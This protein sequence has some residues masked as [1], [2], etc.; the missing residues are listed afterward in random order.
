MP[1]REPSHPL[2][3]SQGIQGCSMR[4]QASLGHGKSVRGPGES[5]EGNPNPK[6]KGTHSPST[7]SALG[8][9]GR[10]SQMCHPLASSLGDSGR[11]GE[12]A[13]TLRETVL[14]RSLSPGQGRPEHPA[15]LLGDTHLLLV[16]FMLGGGLHAPQ[17]TRMP[18]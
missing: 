7:V 12:E 5:T 18:A 8:A 14:S 9:P 10:G 15:L 3:W 13:Q 1:T 11:Y 2:R 6:E 16:P 17:P 4:R